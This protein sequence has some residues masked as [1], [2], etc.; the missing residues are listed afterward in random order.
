MC[1]ISQ[2]GTG[3]LFSCAVQADGG[4][5][6]L[7]DWIGVSFSRRTGKRF[8]EQ[9]VGWG[10]LW[11]WMWWEVLGGASGHFGIFLNFFPGFF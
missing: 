1:A 7:S 5:R 8:V 2:M 6:G 10:F 11:M 4:N 9:P 3:A